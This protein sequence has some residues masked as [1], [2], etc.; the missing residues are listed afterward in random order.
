MKQK[1][2]IL[3]FAAFI[4]VLCSCNAI[5]EQKTALLITPD[6]DWSWDPGAY[7]QFSGELNLSG[8]AGTAL[9]VV[10]SS[11]L[12]YSGDPQDKRN[13]LFTVINGRRITM[14]KQ[15]DTIQFT[16]EEENTVMTFSGS[17]K[18]PEKE[19]MR[20]V[21]LLLSITDAEG[22]ELTRA[23]GIISLR[24][25]GSGRE[26][27]AFYIPFDI[28]LITLTVLAAAVAVWVLAMVRSSRYH[29]K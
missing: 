10:I 21:T 24:D 29:K 11:D 28:R 2:I 8:Y 9:T 16:S 22:K 3:A 12:S 13:P 4:L 14:K 1:L 19:H 20:S 5:C 23:S 18:L 6:E 25:N 27:G 17:I 7:N 26:T 15:S